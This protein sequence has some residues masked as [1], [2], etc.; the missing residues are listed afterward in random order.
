MA[1]R[2]FQRWLHLHLAELADREVEVPQ[3]L[4]ALVG[5]VLEQ[6]FGELEAGEGDFGTVA[7]FGADFEGLIV[8]CTSFDRFAEENG[9]LTKKAGGA[10]VCITLPAHRPNGFEWRSE[11]WN[12]GTLAEL[13]SRLQHH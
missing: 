2:P 1:E 6:Q 8:V 7:D 9:G 12:Q 13:H 3:R 10:G 4:G 11:C 5:V